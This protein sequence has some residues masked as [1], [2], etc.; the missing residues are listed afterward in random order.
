VKA[1]HD[2]DFDFQVLIRKKRVVL[3]K[4]SW[5]AYAPPLRALSK[6]RSTKLTHFK[7]SFRNHNSLS[8]ELSCEQSNR[9][10]QLHQNFERG[11]SLG[12]PD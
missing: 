5:E 8:K 9:N 12:Q 2:Q 10:R 11:V 4:V 3:C 7:S 6:H 1:F